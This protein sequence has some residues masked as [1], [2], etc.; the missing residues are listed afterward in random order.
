M[1]A[2][3]VGLILTPVRPLPNAFLSTNL[4][5]ILPVKGLENLPRISVT[6]GNSWRPGGYVR[7]NYYYKFPLGEGPKPETLLKLPGFTPDPSPFR[8]AATG[9][10]F[11]VEDGIRQSVWVSDL[12]KGTEWK[13]ANIRGPATVVAVAE[14]PIDN[15]TPT[16]W[17]DVPELR[18]APVPPGYPPNLKL[19]QGLELGSV[20]SEPLIPRSPRVN[21]TVQLKL[22]SKENLSTLIAKVIQSGELNGWKKYTYGENVRFR[23]Q[24]WDYGL[25]SIEYIKPSMIVAFGVQSEVMLVYVFADPDNSPRIID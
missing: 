13:W 9:R 14:L 16:R 5:P 2:L 4:Q 11:R 21:V 12:Q 25:V 8:G 1:V 23:R 17:H 3:L 6:R 24:G 18:S 20:M 10:V 19:M 15:E 22:H 7:I